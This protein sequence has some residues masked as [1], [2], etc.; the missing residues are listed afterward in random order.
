MPQ[1][2][3][4]VFNAAY[5]AHQAPEVAGLMN[6]PDETARI[7]RA[8]ELATKGFVIDLPVMGWGWDPYIVMAMRKATGYTWV[9]SLLQAP[10]LVTPGN[11]MLT[12]PD[13]DP[14]SPPAGS[15]RVSVDLADYP[16]YVAPIPAK[17][18]DS[19]A[20]SPV[21]DHNVANLYFVKPWDTNPDGATVTDARGKFKKHIMNPGSM[22]QSQW[23][24]LLAN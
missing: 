5:W 23:Y 1:T 18:A 14:Q 13:Y 6:I 17:P 22:F 16:A 8:V 9:P 24:E 4:Q 12:L 20:Q 3:Q 2:E 21:G 15:I 10:I 11:H 19:N 7:G